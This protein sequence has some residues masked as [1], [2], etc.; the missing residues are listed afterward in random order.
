MHL[1][2]KVDI[3]FSIRICIRVNVRISVSIHT[4]RFP[5]IRVN[6]DIRIYFKINNHQFV[7]ACSS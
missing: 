6:I 3:G 7:Q 4:R 1:K 5:S 2:T